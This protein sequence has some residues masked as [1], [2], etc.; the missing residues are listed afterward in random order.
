MSFLT[1][2][3]Y[4]DAAP[5]LGIEARCC[6]VML[7][8]GTHPCGLR[9]RLISAAFKLPPGTS[10]VREFVPFSVPTRRSFPEGEI[11]ALRSAQHNS[12]PLIVQIA[13]S[14][15]CEE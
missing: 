3:S 15:F 7:Q 4:K 12:A 13:P 5:C 6:Q 9:L 11:L 1:I 2:D 10:S 8:C 14:T